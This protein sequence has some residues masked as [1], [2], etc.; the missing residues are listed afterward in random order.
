MQVVR[1][2]VQL[3]ASSVRLANPVIGALASGVSAHLDAASPPC[4]PVGMCNLYSVTKGQAAIL[5]FTRAMRDR[6]GNLPP[7]PGVFPDYPAPVVRNGEGGERELTI[8][9][10]GMP[11][12]VRPEGA[13]G[14]QRRHQRPQYVV[15]ALAPV[16]RPSAPLHRPVHQLLRIRDAGTVHEGRPVVPS[17]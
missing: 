2:G 12:T 17:S 15:A 10:W 3:S 6:T 9:R 16:A 14:R 11:S 13:H 5:E 4:S 8:M 7:L 1:P